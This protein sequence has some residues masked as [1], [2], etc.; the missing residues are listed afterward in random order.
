MRCSTR[1]AHAAYLAVAVGCFSSASFAGVVRYEATFHSTWSG[2]TH[3]VD[4]PGVAAHWSPLIGGTH[5][6]SVEY[7]APGQLA[8]PGIEVMAE[9][10]NRE[11]LATEIAA[12][13]GAGAIEVVRGGQITSTPDQSAT[14]IFSPDAE[15]SLVTL[16][17]MV[18][19]SPDWF[20]G[21]HGLDLIQ[22]G[23]WAKEIVVDLLPYDAGTDDG[24]SFA[25]ADIEP[26]QHQ[27]IRRLTSF[28]FENTGRMGTFTFRLLDPE[29]P[30]DANG[31]SRVDLSDFGVL[32]SHFG[33]TTLGASSTGDFDQSGEVNIKDFALLRQNLQSSPAVATTV[34]EPATAPFALMGALVCVVARRMR[35]AKTGLT[36]RLISTHC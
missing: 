7:W 23:R 27:S 8:S 5:N 25:S 24:A 12:T 10:G 28:P 17:S 14:A 16:V 31:D 35:N 3:P 21:V 6:A 32:R 30:G 26:A 36:R 11:P 9:R 19:P 33:E 4:Y 2:L 15:H 18:A 1:I 29:L 13:L 22:D 20:V 34:P